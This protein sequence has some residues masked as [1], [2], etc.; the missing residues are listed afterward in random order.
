MQETG[1]HTQTNRKPW[2]GP[3]E[4]LIGP[5]VA[6]MAA[7]VL[8]GLCVMGW[9]SMRAERTAT[10]AAS[11]A[12]VISVSQLLADSTHAMLSDGDLSATRRLLVEAGRQVSYTKCR[13]EL[14]D[15]SILADQTPSEVTAH[16]LPDEWPAGQTIDEVIQNVSE[17]EL[18][19][20]YPIQLPGRGAVTLHVATET[21]QLAGAGLGENMTPVVTATITG[22]VLILI[23]LL[24]RPAKSRVAPYVMI[25]EALL[26]I[27][28]GEAEPDALKVSDQMGPEVKAWNQLVNQREERD[29]SSLLD[30][31]L[32]SAA[33]GE[34]GSG[35]FALIGDALWHGVI[36]ISTQ[37]RVTYVNGA[38]AVLLKS[39]REDML[40]AEVGGVFDDPTVV[41]LI[42]EVAAGKDGRRRTHETVCEQTG[43]LEAFRHSIRLTGEGPNK[44]VL[45]VIEDVTQ[46][47]VA[48]QTRRDFVAQ[49]AHELRTPLTNISLNVEAAV[50]DGEEDAKL[51]GRCLNVINQESQRLAQV[52]N[53]ML[54]VSE[55]EAGSM[56]LRHDDIRLDA[57]FADLAEDFRQQAEEKQ[58]S[59]KLDLPPKLPVIQGDRDKLAISLHNLLGNAIKYSTDG[60][61]VVVSASAEDG[62]LTVAV[63]D[64]GIGIDKDELAKVFDRFYRAKD[65]R[66]SGITGTGLGLPIAREIVRRH[67]GDIEATSELNQGSTFTLHMPY[68]PEAA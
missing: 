27:D 59:L 14:P 8:I 3:A 50:D 2:L 30:R 35:S 32:A 39:S 64:K 9:W 15:G 56:T 58:V 51:R 62:Q 22:G 68:K 60:G 36:L 6:A 21:E 7:S 63:K 37:M 18:S 5:I 12:R 52:V 49:V 11:T 55:I 4:A 1:E 45:V 13:I 43:H 54:S 17:G 67:G 48:E 47:R 28:R 65:S 53:D 33:S 41:E 31:A 29:K 24:W 34:A 23:V 38:A 40:N 42:D 19:I 26:S 57:L 61:E 66:L 25:R 46:Q 44:K 20:R 16:A 10:V